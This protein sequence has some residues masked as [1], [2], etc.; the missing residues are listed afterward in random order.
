MA[1]EN[2]LKPSLLGFKGVGFNRVLPSPFGFGNSLKQD[3][4]NDYLT[5]PEAVGELVNVFFG[6]VFT[7]EAWNKT[8]ASYT[9]SRYMIS[10]QSSGNYIGCNI[11]QAGNASY[12]V[13]GLGVNESAG[14]PFSSVVNGVPYY[15]VAVRRTSVIN[16]Y[17]NTLAGNPGV[18]GSLGTTNIMTT[19]NIGSYN[20]GTTHVFG[21]DE[22]RFYTREMSP[23]EIINNYNNGAG[24][25]PSDVIGL[26]LWFDFE[27]AEVAT[28]LYPGGLPSGW[29]SS[30]WGIRNKAAQDSWPK[31]YHAK[32]VNMTNNATLGGVLTSW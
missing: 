32:A 15:V 17:G 3:M 7:I 20:N 11:T 6:A 5:I 26:K 12:V 8:S 31:K 1:L 14:T 18:L 30:D 27:Q 25:N 22:L 29:T 23:Y 28:D 24:S 9:G 21:L 13:N 4:V 2:G 19:F 10:A 16:C